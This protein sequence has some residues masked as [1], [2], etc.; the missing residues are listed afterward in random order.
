MTHTLI[1][2]ASPEDVEDID[3][4]LRALAESTGESTDY[5]GNIQALRKY[6]FSKH[7]IYRALLAKHED[8]CVGLCT[9]YPEFSSWRCQS[10]LYVLDLYVDSL[11][12]G[13][14]L[15]RQLLSE[16]IRYAR[17]EWQASYMRLSVMKTNQQGRA[18]YA[19][20]GFQSDEENKLLVLQDTAF[21]AL[22]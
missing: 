19:K 1:R 3:H 13:E 2:T 18:F 6:G 11:A 15:G 22:T 20:L 9:F 14:G 7:S 5:T 17:E 12:R 10:G 4:L 16:A 8:T 21:D